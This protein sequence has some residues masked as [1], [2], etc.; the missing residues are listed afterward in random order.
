M[1]L[2]TTGADGRCH[3]TRAGEGATV[4]TVNVLPQ[5]LAEHFTADHESVFLMA[6][7]A[8][9]HLIQRVD[10]TSGVVTLQ[11]VVFAVAGDT[12]G[13]AGGR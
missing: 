8:G 5:P 7:S 2:V 3:Q 10:G 6:T 1:S 4:N 9:F 12:G 11:N 13:W